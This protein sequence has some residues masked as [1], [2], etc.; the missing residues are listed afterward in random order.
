MIKVRARQRL[1]GPIDN[2]N[3]SDEVCFDGDK[4]YG[5]DGGQHQSSDAEQ[6]PEPSAEQL[7]YVESALYVV[8][9]VTGGNTVEVILHEAP[10]FASQGNSVP[11]G[12]K[13]K[14]SLARKWD[15]S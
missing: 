9:E 6:P 13:V 7:Q 12:P 4:R 1:P 14:Q 2:R 10:M 5:S 11:R 15:I 3:L 8:A